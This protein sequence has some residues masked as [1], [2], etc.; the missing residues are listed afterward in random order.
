MVTKLETNY[1]RQRPPLGAR[2]ACSWGGGGTGKPVRL[3][4][5]TPL[6]QAFTQQ[7]CCEWEEVT[8]VATWTG[9]GLGKA[10]VLTIPAVGPGLQALLGAGLAAP[11][12]GGPG[13]H[14]NCTSP[15]FSHHF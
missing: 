15:C 10:G 14:V 9:Q 6:H 13:Q 7:Q 12:L 2:E 5:L 11:A 8:V 4:S 3:V 1:S